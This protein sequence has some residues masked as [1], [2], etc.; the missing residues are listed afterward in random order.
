MGYEKD[1][2]KEI[3][4]RDWK[5]S[6]TITKIVRRHCAGCQSYGPVYSV[7]WKGGKRTFPCPAGCEKTHD[8]RIHII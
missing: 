4:S 5:K 1:V 3:L 6:G 2:G 7:W 8:G